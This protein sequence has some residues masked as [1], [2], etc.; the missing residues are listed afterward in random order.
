MDKHLNIVALNVPYPPNYGGVIDIYYKLKALHDAGV[1][2]VLHCFE[3][4]RPPARELAPLCE[5]VYYYRRRT[6]WA[7]N[8]TLLPYNVYSRKNPDLIANLLKND[9]PVLF[10]GLHSCYYIGDKRLA[11]RCK[12]YR[13]SNIEHDYYRLLARS[14]HC[15]TVKTFMRIE[16]WRFKWY[17]RV[18]AHACLTLAVSATD[19]AYLR[20][21]FPGK[22]IECMPTFHANDEITAQP[23]LSGFIL[24]HGKLSVAEN[25]HAALYLIKHVFSRLSHPCVIAGMN[26]SRRLADA[27]AAHPHITLEA[28]PSGQRMNRLIREAQIHLLITFQDTGLKLKLLNSLFAGRHVVANRLMLAGSG[29][30]PLCHIADTPDEM[31]EACNRLMQLPFTPECIAERSALLIPAYSNKHQ[32]QRLYGMIYE[33]L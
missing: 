28:N 9:Y 32:A 27:V 25:E 8:V 16:A 21:R 1:K 2:I 17:E 6:G 4:E 30:D 11:G 20:G 3:Y 7:A 19:T 29:L 14:S 5:E 18:I 33:N 15:F 12:I 31:A 13:A 22:R 23:G 26:P 10:E 24:Y